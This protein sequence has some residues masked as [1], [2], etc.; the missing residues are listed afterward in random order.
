M[1]IDEKKLVECNGIPFCFAQFYLPNDF[2]NSKVVFRLETKLYMMGML[3]DIKFGW[4]GCRVK[5]H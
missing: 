5:S 2:S 3:Y 4:H 1:A